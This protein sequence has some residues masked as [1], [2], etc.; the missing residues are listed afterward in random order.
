MSKL[1]SQT[2]NRPCIRGGPIKPIIKTLE[3]LIAATFAVKTPQNIMAVEAILAQVK[4]IPTQL[5]AVSAEVNYLTILLE[6]VYHT[7]ST[8]LTKS[9]LAQV[10]NAKFIESRT[11][12]KSQKKTRDGEI[13]YINDARVMSLKQLQEED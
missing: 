3:N 4:K 12:K 13:T 5:E 6:K 2:S 9:K 10:Q 7:A 8:A 1:S 11:K